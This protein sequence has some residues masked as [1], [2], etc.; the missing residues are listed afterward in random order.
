[1]ARRWRAKRQVLIM[2]RFFQIAIAVLFCG[3][4][5]GSL[6]GASKAAEGTDRGAHD[7][8]N[9]TYRI[10]GRP[11]ALVDGLHESPAAPGSATMVRTTVWQHPVFGD[12]DGDGDPDAVTC[13]EVENLGVFWYE[14]PYAVPAD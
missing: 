5:F 13:E 1:M 3:L 7:P 12:L 9:T 2:K 11:V 8:L 10:E 6:A 4:V 14:N